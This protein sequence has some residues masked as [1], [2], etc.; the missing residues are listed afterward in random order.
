MI[1]IAAGEAR[2]AI[3]GASPRMFRIFEDPVRCAMGTAMREPG[4]SRLSKM[5][6]MSLLADLRAPEKPGIDIIRN[7]FSI[8]PRGAVV[9]QVQIG[10]GLDLT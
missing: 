2:N 10:E 6:S 7:D 3:E 9:S 5:S 4:T 1:R 8:Y